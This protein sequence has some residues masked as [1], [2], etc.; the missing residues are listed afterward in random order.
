MIPFLKKLSYNFKLLFL[1]VVKHIQHKIYHL[2]HFLVYG[3]V[4]LST[5]TLLCNHHHHLPSDLLSCKT[6]TLSPL[7]TNSPFPSPMMA[8]LNMEFIMNSKQ[9]SCS[10]TRFLFYFILYTYMLIISE[11]NG[12]SEKVSI[13]ERHK[14]LVWCNREEFYT[15]CPRM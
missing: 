12:A 14:K 2:N 9:L 6:K 8:L 7:N 15:V 5:F 11:N 10:N 13:M 1:V 4:A 3:S